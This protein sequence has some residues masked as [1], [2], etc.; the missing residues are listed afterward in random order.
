MNSRE[1]VLL[2]CPVRNRIGCRLRIRSGRWSWRSWLPERGGGG[3]AEA[4]RY[5]VD[6]RFVSFKP[7]PAQAEFEEYVRASPR[8]PHRSGDACAATTS[9]VTGPT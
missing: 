5:R 7:S 1:R 8:H 6:V 2:P 3:H 4:E 9:G